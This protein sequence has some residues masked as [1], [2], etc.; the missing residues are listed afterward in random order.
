MLGFGSGFGST[1]EEILL[2]KGIPGCCAYRT[3]QA[4]AWISMR[5][6]CVV[7]WPKV[8]PGGISRGS[9]AFARS[10]SLFTKPRGLNADV[11][12]KCKAGHGR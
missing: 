1:F 5:T 4:L 10:G 6:L 11:G 9:V 2:V 8:S 7:A 12:T 3:R